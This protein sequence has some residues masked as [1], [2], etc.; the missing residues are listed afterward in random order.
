M[1]A[2]NTIQF[3]IYL[4]AVLIVMLTI[5]ATFQPFEKKFNN[6]LSCCMFTVLLLM[7]TLTIN[8]YS[9]VQTEGNTKKILAIHWI[10]V[11]LCCI[12]I[13]VGL[14]ICGRWVVMKIKDRK[15]TSAAKAAHEESLLLD[16][17]MSGSYSMEDRAGSTL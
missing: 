4:E 6:I 3:N 17:N 13:V 15:Q 7:N 16:R 11:M 8:V 1:A 10:Q 5:Q 9:L 12:P 2:K 14:G